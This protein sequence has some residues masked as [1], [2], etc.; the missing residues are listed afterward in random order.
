ME[1]EGRQKKSTGKIT[2]FSPENA[3]YPFLRLHLFLSSSNKFNSSFLALGRLEVDRGQEYPVL[4]FY[5]QEES[6]V[7]ANN[8][9][10]G[11]GDHSS[12][13]TN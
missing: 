12:L 7:R 4:E 8:F 13:K 1:D 10:P 11:S 5:K 3:A 9:L 2:P 6:V